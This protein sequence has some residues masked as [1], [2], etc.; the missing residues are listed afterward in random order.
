MPRKCV[1]I[2]DICMKKSANC[3]FHMLFNVSSEPFAGFGI[4]EVVTANRYFMVLSEVS[5]NWL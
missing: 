4:V 2:T 1:Y 5:K 3:L